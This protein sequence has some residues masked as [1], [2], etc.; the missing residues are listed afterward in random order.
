MEMSEQYWKD[1]ADALERALR[2]ARPLVEKWCHYQGDHPKLFQQY[3][4][5]I[6]A[7]LTDQPANGS[8][9]ADNGAHRHCA[10]KVSSADQPAQETSHKQ[11]M[12]GIMF[13]E[14]S[15]LKVAAERAA[16]GRLS[17][18][19][20]LIYRLVDALRSGAGPEEKKSVE[21]DAKTW[22]ANA[23]LDDPSPL[24]DQPAQ[25]G[26]PS[27]DQARF[28]RVWQQL[29]Y[30]LAD[31]FALE[32]TDAQARSIAREVLQAADAG[33]PSCCARTREDEHEALARLRWVLWDA[34]PD[35]IRIA[36]DDP[37]MNTDW[38][39][40]CAAIRRTGDTGGQDE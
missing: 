38:Q 25:D 36:R 13:C 10:G 30:S 11:P 16:Q 40:I 5:P 8:L 3:L 6:D 32:A 4:G 27:V 12:S 29:V 22:L 24:A 20:S 7:A 28:K 1:R 33:E 19:P 9:D 21:R 17:D 26:E 31:F 35:S 34:D 18:A 23:N 15:D 37:G 14:R 39:T 2:D